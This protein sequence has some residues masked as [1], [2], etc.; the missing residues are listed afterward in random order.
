MGGGLSVLFV[1]GTEGAGSDL[2]VDD[3]LVVFAGDAGAELLINVERC[4]TVTSEANG[5]DVRQ[6][7]RTSIRAVRILGLHHLAFRR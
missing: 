5:R 7:R 2:V 3:G 6:C 1:E 4:V